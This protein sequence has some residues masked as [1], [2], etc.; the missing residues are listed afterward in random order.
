MISM[1]EQDGYRYLLITLGAPSRNDTYEDALSFYKWGFSS[2][3]LQNILKAGDIAGEISVSLSSQQD[4]VLLVAAEDVNAIL[5]KETDSTAVQQV[6]RT[7]DSVRAPVT[8][9]EVLGRMDFKL[10]DEVIA[11]VDLVAAEDVGRS[12]LLYAG[13]VT[14]RFFTQPLVLAGVILLLLLIGILYGWIR[15]I[16]KNRRRRAERIRRIGR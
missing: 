11:S 4:Y 8:K 2:F 6:M 5:P 13:D 12:A 9:G 15:Q 1:A 7:V 14:L 16:R 3:S 10:A